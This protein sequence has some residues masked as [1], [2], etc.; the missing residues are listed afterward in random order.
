MLDKQTEALEKIN[1]V[2]AA[3]NMAQAGQGQQLSD[4]ASMGVAPGV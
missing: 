4:L 3:M 1:A 2:L